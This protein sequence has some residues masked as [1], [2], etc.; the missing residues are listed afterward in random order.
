MPQWPSDPIL[1]SVQRSLP[2]S[3]L[4]SKSTWATAYG[5]S[6]E[7]VRRAFWIRRA[8]KT[9][10]AFRWKESEGFPMGSFSTSISV[11]WIPFRS[12]HPIALRKASFAANRRAKHSEGRA[13]FLTPYDFLLCKDPAEEEVS[14]AS[15]SAARSAPYSRYQ[16]PYR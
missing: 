10:F 16:C 13:P 4:P 12:P 1:A 6:W 7:R 3:F 9:S 2:S 5:R 8:P 11:H 14:P 15:S